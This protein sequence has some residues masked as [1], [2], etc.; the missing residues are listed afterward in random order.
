MTLKLTFPTL[1]KKIQGCLQVNFPFIQILV[2]Q[3][4]I[5][6]QRSYLLTY[7]TMHSQAAMHSDD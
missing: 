6:F 5:S 4:E 7:I 1:V 3:L 2:P